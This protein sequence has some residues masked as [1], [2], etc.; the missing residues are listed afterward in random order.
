MKDYE[1]LLG[2]IIF[3][4][5]GKVANLQESDKELINEGIVKRQAKALQMVSE[6]LGIPVSD[7]IAFMIQKEIDSASELD[8]F[9]RDVKK[10]REENK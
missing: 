4:E 9:K 1:E 10:F 8:K 7:L 6:N 3:K 5:L 2:D